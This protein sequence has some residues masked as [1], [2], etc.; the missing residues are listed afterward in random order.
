MSD[1]RMDA[2]RPPADGAVDALGT[3]LA[4]AASVAAWPATPDLA[5][6]LVERLQAPAGP[7]L[8]PGVLARIGEAGRGG[9]RPR[10][11]LG[12]ALVLAL[13]ALLALAG[14]AAALGFRLP[15]FEL[16][17][18]SETPAAGS[19][20]SLG[21]PVPLA[22]VLTGDG[23]DVRLPVALPPPDTAYVLGAADRT[24]V[25]VAWRAE[26]GQRTIGDTDLALT[27][28]AVRGGTEEP[29][30]RKI[31]G[32][33]TFV[34]AVRVGDD[35]GW[36]ISGAPHEVLFVRP[37]GTIGVLAEGIAGDTLVFA[38]DGTLYRLETALGRE[39]TLELAGAM[40]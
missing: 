19:G 32:P 28:S 38:R 16:L 6:R 9:G 34:E 31:A 4:A 17:R 33:G 24:I 37:D 7:D 23:P 39:R 30:V 27:L 11:R 15:G 13:V 35:P 26:P 20:L 22:E 10:P 3:R 36:W 40:P 5:A 14:V 2:A 12:R 21:S 1:D 18:T 25:T 29:L 8:R